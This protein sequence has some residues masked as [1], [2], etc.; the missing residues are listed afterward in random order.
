MPARLLVIFV[1]PVEAK[2]IRTQLAEKTLGNAVWE[3]SV[4]D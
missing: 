1:K 3:R 2:N 4:N